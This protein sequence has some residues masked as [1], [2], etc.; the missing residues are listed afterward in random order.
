MG[1]NFTYIGSKRK[2]DTGTKMDFSIRNSC[3]D[4][5]GKEALVRNIFV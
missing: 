5:K 4:E 3:I 2:S 1:D